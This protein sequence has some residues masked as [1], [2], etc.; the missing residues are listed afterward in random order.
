MPGAEQDR[1]LRLATF[2]AAGQVYARHIDFGEV[3]YAAGG[4]IQSI[5]IA[6]SSGSPALDEQALAVARMSRL[7]KAPEEL[8]GQAFAV[9][10]PI[11]FRSAR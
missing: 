3:R 10:F 8:S 9:R 5:V 6:E 11:V 4:F 7:P 2:L 1:S